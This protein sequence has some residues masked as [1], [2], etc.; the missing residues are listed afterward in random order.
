M[1]R[2]R[3]SDFELHALDT[4]AAA[5]LRVTDHRKDMPKKEETA[6]ERSKP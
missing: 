6:L 1:R 2:S 5:L 4:E 3:Y